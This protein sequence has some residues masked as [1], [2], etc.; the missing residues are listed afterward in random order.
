MASTRTVG[1]TQTS[2]SGRG[3]GGGDTR[4]VLRLPIPY[5]KPVT[6]LAIIQGKTIR[7]RQSQD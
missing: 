4:H 1:S 2:S 5:S 3:L 6:L 7:C